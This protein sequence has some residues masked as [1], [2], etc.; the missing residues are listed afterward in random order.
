[1]LLR[2]G[3]STQAACGGSFS[4]EGFIQSPNYPS[5]YPNDLD[6]DYVITV[7]GGATVT[8]TFESLDVETNGN[9][10]YDYVQVNL[11]WN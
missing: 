7:E 11:I 6:C 1:M 3:H 5:Y 9:A 2:V 8:L 4:D 10:C